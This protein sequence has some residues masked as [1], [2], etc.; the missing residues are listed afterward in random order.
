MDELNLAISETLQKTG[1]NASYID[2]STKAVIITGIL[3]VTFIATRVFRYLVTPVL[4]SISNQTKATWD[5][6]LFD[7]KVMHS[8]CRLIPPILWYLLLPLT[9][10]DMPELLK[11][12]QKI[13]MIYLIV[14]VLFFIRRFLNSLYDISSQHETWGDRPLK[15]IYQMIKLVAVCIGAILILSILIGKDA[16]TILAGL[17]ASAA[18]L[19]LIFKDS[20]LGLVAG[21]Q[22]SANDM[23]RPGDWITMNKYGADG[24]VTE[25]TLTTVKVQNF[26][27]TITTIPPYALVS[28][29]FQNWRGMWESGGRRI[30]RSFLIDANTV[31]FC[32]EEELNQFRQKGW[33]PNQ[34]TETEHR[35][36][37]NLEVFRNHMLHYIQQHPGIHPD[38]LQMV[39]MLQPTSE[40]I[41]IEVYCFTRTTEWIPYEILQAEISDHIIAVIPAFGLKLFQRPSGEDLQRIG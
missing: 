38:L 37:V 21:I 9:F 3:L 41:P 35:E 27:K 28:D 14:V 16:T 13:C 40:G 31:H 23:L 36:I 30:R 6:H 19:M 25:V 8:V 7:N 11:I 10:P 34:E 17:G 39:R 20:I 32:S 12:L 15:G 22:L 33:L 18:I 4:Q 2:W 1:L 29:S 5:D 24:N 26:D